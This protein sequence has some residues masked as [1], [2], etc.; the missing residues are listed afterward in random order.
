[1]RHSQMIAILIAISVFVLA[2]VPAPAQ[3]QVE[4]TLWHSWQWPE[5][6]VL[7]TWI[8]GYPA[9]REGRAVVKAEYV[10]SFSIPERL[11]TSPE[12]PDLVLGSSDWAD[13]FWAASLIG[14]LDLKLDDA[15]RATLSP[16]AWQ[17]ARYGGAT[18]A[19]PLTLEGM[20]FY[21]NIA[22]VG[23]EAL[24][25]TWD[26][27]VGEIAFH[28]KGDQVGMVA[29]LGF[30]QTGGMFFALGGQLMT[31]SGASRLGEGTA[32]ADYFTILQSYVAKAKRGEIAISAVS[33][34]FPQGKAA[35]KLAGNWDLLHLRGALGD[36]LGVLNPP[37]VNGKAWR[38]FVRASQLY[39][40][41]GSPDVDASLDFARYVTSADAQQVAAQAG[42]LPVNPAAYDADAQVGQV[43]G[44]LATDGMPIPSR[45]EMAIY[46]REM[47]EAL[48]A[49]LVDGRAPGEV[50]AETI[51]R[52]DAA[53]K[54][55]HNPATPTPVR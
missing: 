3:A 18:V 43:A 44:Q 6:K 32:L 29:N 51:Q 55:L 10:P 9:A 28:S 14:P 33:D 53:L 15:Y 17:L 24:P 22:L 37:T 30:Y 21:Y 31:D 12:K 19:V 48:R 26:D 20:V 38:P 7:Q 2:P 35:Y 41:Q 27:L 49:V 52:V 39:V 13:P 46:W 16:L 47:D 40:V 8:A 34:A 45:P 54:E 1:M 5:N 42:L 23:D 11:R 4:I 25:R 50:A 36:K